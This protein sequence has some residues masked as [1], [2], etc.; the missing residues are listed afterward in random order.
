MPRHRDVV[1][2]GVSHLRLVFSAKMLRLTTNALPDLKAECEGD[3][4]RWV[5]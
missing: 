4:C 5:A 2:D 1:V 3:E